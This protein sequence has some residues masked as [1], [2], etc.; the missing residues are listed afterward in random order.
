M[1]HFNFLLISVALSFS[2]NSISQSNWDGFD[3]IGKVTYPFFN[4]SVFN[5]S[6]SNPSTTGVNTSAKCA[7]Y[8]RDGASQYDVILIN[9]IGLTKIASVAD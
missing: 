7:Q 3:N 9:P 8:T 2:F 6:F 4:G 5:E 1:K